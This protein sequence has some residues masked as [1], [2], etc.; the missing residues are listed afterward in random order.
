MNIDWTFVTPLLIFILGLY[1]HLR[2]KK[3]E[4]DAETM[5]LLLKDKEALKEREL[6][7]W[8]EHYMDIGVS[9][10]DTLCNIK[11][12]IAAIKETLHEKVDWK[13]CDD[14]MQQLDERL[15]AA[16]L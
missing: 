12:T 13:N 7:T 14:K 2:E 8:R 1:M 5:A 4:D 3:R 11:N 9:N 16:K 6:T 10:K 15:R